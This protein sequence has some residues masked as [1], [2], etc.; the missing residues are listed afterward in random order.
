MTNNILNIIT[1]INVIFLTIL[2]TTTQVFSEQFH[3]SSVK[4]IDNQIQILD[5]EITD[6]SNKIR[7]LQSDS[8][9][10]ITEYNTKKIQ[11]ENSLS[12]IESSL[13]LAKSNL[14]NFQM[15]LQDNRQDLSLIHI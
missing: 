15:Q 14:Q 7:N 5:S 3:G 13:T 11:L 2:I 8:I 9:R 1:R 4:T 10:V 6:I 12:D